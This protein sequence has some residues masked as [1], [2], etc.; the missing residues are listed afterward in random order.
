M[1]PADSVVAAGVFSDELFGVADPSAIIGIQF[2]FPSAWTQARGPNI[3][4]RD[5]RTTDGA[6]LLA[7][8]LPAGTTLDKLPT[9]FFTDTL[10]AAGGKYGMYGTVDDYRVL[11]SVVEEVDGIRYRTLE[12]KFAALSFNYNSVERRLLLRAAVVGRGVYLLAA[13]ALANRYPTASPQLRG[14]CESFRVRSI[15]TARAA[16]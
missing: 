1:I 12:I 9:S 14:I 15:R 3:D 5:I 2:S 13:S 10:F 8:P 7:T 6:F 11:S 16:R 4:L